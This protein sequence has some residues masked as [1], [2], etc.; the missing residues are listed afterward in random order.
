MLPPVAHRA[1]AARPAQQYADQY[2]TIRAVPHLLCWPRPEKFFRLPLSLFTPYLA[3]SHPP[4]PLFL[5]REMLS[6]L[7]AASA[8]DSRPLSQPQRN[9]NI[10]YHFLLFP[11]PFPPFFSKPPTPPP[12]ALSIMTPPLSVARFLACSYPPA[13]ALLAPCT[14]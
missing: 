9:S 4:H 14:V 12:V 5:L 11:H 7:G 1:V 2:C 3:T 8:S 6:S 13:L 10:P